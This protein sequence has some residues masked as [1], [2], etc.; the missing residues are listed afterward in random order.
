VDVIPG[1]KRFKFDKDSKISLNAMDP[2]LDLESVRLPLMSSLALIAMKDKART[3]LNIEEHSLMWAAM[4]DVIRYCGVQDNGL[5]TSPP[6]LPMVVE[7][8]FH[9]TEGMATGMHMTL[10]ELAIG[11]EYGRYRIKLALALDRYVTG[12][13]KGMFHGETSSGLFT[14]APFVAM[15]C[16]NLEDEHQAA[17][18][19]ILNFLGSNKLSKE[20]STRQF[21]EV[22]NDETWKLSKDPRF[23]TALIE[24]LKLGR[25]RDIAYT[26]V[27]HHLM[28][29]VRIAG[30]AIKGLI[31][32][33]DH[34]WIYGQNESELE[35]SAKELRV[36]DPAL[37]KLIVNLEAGVAVRRAG[38]KLPPFL[39]KNYATKQELPLLE[40]SHGAMGV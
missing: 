14:S 10:D 12:D 40:T 15:D 32:D 7:K 30:E 6:I 22:I 19:V 5:P 34:I 9:P 24:G 29:A 28:D 3:E 8:L 37:K 35:A 33:C 26:F 16:E 1:A 23:V 38:K 36:N 17:V 39:V 13:M 21:D 2:A 18:V 25:T 31:G 20:G 11:S 4:Q 27:F